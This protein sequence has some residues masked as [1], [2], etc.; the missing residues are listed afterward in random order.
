MAHDK[1][2]AKRSMAVLNKSQQS[3]LLFKLDGFSSAADSCCD[4]CQGHHDPIAIPIDCAGVRGQWLAE[5]S[6][7]SYDVLSGY[8]LPFV[9]KNQQILGGAGTYLIRTEDERQALLQ[10][11]RGGV[12]SQLLA[13][14]TKHN[15]HLGPGNLLLSDFVADPIGD[16]G[17]T[18]FVTDEA[19][20]PIFLAASEQITDDDN[21][22]I[23]STI[24]YDR[25]Q[26]L[27]VKFGPLVNKIAAW[28][29]G[30]GYVEPCGADILETA[31]R[32]HETNGAN[33]G[34]QGWSDF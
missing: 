15:H 1:A 34:S 33:S 13:A 7:K 16:Y 9:L 6:Q 26:E 3:K 19:T 24:N 10:D 30:D 18:F 32:S 31:P 12:L 14:V 21:A 5:Q 29:R 11:F 23:G 28:L 22:W 20:D 17:I 25:Q 8:P 4:F 2:E 27:K